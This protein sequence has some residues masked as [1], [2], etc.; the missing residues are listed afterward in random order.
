MSLNQNR[1]P[2]RR[3]ATTAAESVVGPSE[4]KSSAAVVTSTESGLEVP[5]TA[6]STTTGITTYDSFESMR[7]APLLLKG[8]YAKGF[9][10]PSAIQQRALVPFLQRRD[11]IAQAQ[12][13]TGKTS[14]L[15]IG[16]LGRVDPTLN[17][18][19]AIVL[20]PTRELAVQTA[21]ACA[22][23]G[24]FMH[25]STHACIGGTSLV[26]DARR[27]DNGV[28]IVSGTPGRV[29]DMLTR[30]HLRARHVC[31][32]ILDEADEMLSKG[33]KPQ[34]YDVYRHLPPNVQ[35]VLASA[36]LPHETLELTAKFMTSP[37][38]ILV[39]RDELTL[40]GI[41]Q[42]FVSV[43]K[44]DWK[45][46]TLCDLYDTLTITLAV[47]FV[48]TKRKCIW[49]A[50]MMKRRGF[51][52]ASIHGDLPQSE[53]DA[54]MASFRRGDARVLIATDVWA[55][56]LDV[57][58]VSLVI[59]YDLPQSREN[60]LHRIGRSGRFGKRGVAINF[61]TTSDVAMLRDIEMF[62]ATQIDEMP[63]NVTELTA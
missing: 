2:A 57:L 31:L 50:D 56:G 59:N 63:M 15:A 37:V 3:E 47:I 55:R 62:Y 58:Q 20:S 52:V 11:L 39:R 27:L 10:K 42:F 34:I 23:L 25:V 24:Q 46:D 28:Q 40:E 51:T 12:S 54:T 29:F 49:L 44:E 60:Y 35:V 5:A 61:V 14:F 4:S 48:N 8:L 21:R 17:E 16:M 1:R 32:L 38:R 13:G 53:R 7:I 45:F 43:E 41:R 26:E 9:H 18:T 33:F 36:T 30:R 6:F 19:Q 22:E